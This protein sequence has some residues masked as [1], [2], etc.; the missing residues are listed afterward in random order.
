VPDDRSACDAALLAGRTLTE[1][2][3]GSPA[4]LALAGLA[5]ELAGRTVEPRARGRRRS[6]RL[7][8]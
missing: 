2:A 8:A 7:R 1:A 3:S 6:A 5:A 4:R